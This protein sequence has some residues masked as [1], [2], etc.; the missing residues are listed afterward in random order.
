VLAY[1]DLDEV[2]WTNWNRKFQEACAIV[3]EEREE[4]VPY[5]CM[6]SVKHESGKILSGSGFFSYGVLM[7][8]RRWSG[9]AKR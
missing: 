1:R 5:R 2:E 8:L 4:Q 3:T 7:Y 6:F 9:C